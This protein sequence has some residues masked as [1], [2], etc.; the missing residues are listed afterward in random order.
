MDKKK[1]NSGVIVIILL[2]VILALVGIAIAMTAIFLS[3]EVGFSRLLGNGYKPIELSKEEVEIRVG[4]TAQ[5][6]VNNYE[7]LLVGNGLSY[8]SSN[9]DVAFI[10]EEYADGFDVKG[11]SPGT[12]KVTV[13]GAGLEDG[14]LKLTVRDDTSGSGGMEGESYSLREEYS[15][16]TWQIW[17]MSGF[18]L[19]DST[20]DKTAYVFSNENGEK[21]WAYGGMPADIYYYMRPNEP[22]AEKNEYNEAYSFESHEIGKAPDGGT[23]YMG[24]RYN[25]QDIYG[26]TEMY[27]VFFEYKADGG[28]SSDYVVLEFSPEVAGEWEDED[29]GKA[30]RDIFGY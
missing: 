23:L 5:I 24:Y 2:I 13:Q 12:V 29:Y 26:E 19:E 28:Y 25:P 4:E 22:G 7:E 3:R 10:M 30:A 21:Y 20:E 17:P 9:P 14:V 27:Y 15:T 11:I 16:N 1:K 8:V 6:D 18:S